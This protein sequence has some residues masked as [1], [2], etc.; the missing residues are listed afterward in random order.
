MATSATANG[1]NDHLQDALKVVIIGAGIGGL[2]TAA[3]LAH[4]GHEVIVWLE[5]ED[6]AELS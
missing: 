6:G 1:Q 4:Q 3:L 2:S 5:G